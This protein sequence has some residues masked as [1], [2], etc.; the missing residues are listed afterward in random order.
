MT[1]SCL[2]LKQNPELARKRHN[3]QNRAYYARNKEK[4]AAGHRRWN[5]A[6]S[7]YKRDYWRK[8]YR[9][10]R[11]MLSKPKKLSIFL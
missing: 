11:N 7:T 10:K 6:H 4:V 1:A 5:A 8:K 9:E 2:F 3:E